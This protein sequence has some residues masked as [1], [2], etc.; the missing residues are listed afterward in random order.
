MLIIFSKLSS[1]K[2]KRESIIFINNRLVDSEFLRRTIILTYQQEYQCIHDELGG[3]FV[4]LSLEMDPKYIDANIHPNKKE[5]KFF[6]E[7]EICKDF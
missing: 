1:L 7:T 4:Y 5:V 3:F 6:N 2:T